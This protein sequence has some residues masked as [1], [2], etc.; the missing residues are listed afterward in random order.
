VLSKAGKAISRA[1]TKVAFFEAQNQRLQAQV[2]Q[3]TSRYTRKRVRINPN[4]R[5][6][7]VVKIKT[8]QDR[9]VIAKAEKAIKKAVDRTNKS[10]SKAATHMGQAVLN[11]N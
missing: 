1:N 6:S 7:N 10:I 8:A 5:F 11:L 3:L 9:A 4:E 2:D